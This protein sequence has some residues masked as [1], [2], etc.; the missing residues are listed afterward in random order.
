MITTD[1]TLYSQLQQSERKIQINKIE[2]SGRWNISNSKNSVSFIPT[3]RKLYPSH[4]ASQPKGQF[5]FVV[6]WLWTAITVDGASQTLQRL[7]YGSI[8]FP[9]INFIPAGFDTVAS[10]YMKSFLDAYWHFV[11]SQKIN[12]NVL[13]TWLRYFKRI[14]LKTLT[15]LHKCLCVI[16]SNKKIV[17]AV[18]KKKRNK[19][20]FCWLCTLVSDLPH[21]FY[22][23]SS[24]SKILT[25]RVQ[26]TN[27]RNKRV[28]V[29]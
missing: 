9:E 15:A 20:I 25:I 12:G 13:K 4:N 7:I 1:Q 28:P 19:N 27:S 2:Q 26:I 11:K 14:S 16:L 18:K 17:T 6:S 5:G 29:P 10:Q 24:I 8:A 23:R 3:I 21:W 22:T